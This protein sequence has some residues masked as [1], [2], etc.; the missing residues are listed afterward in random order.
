MFAVP[1]VKQERVG[2]VGMECTHRSNSNQLVVTDPISILAVVMAILFLC[3]PLAYVLLQRP[4]AVRRAIF[5]AVVNF[6]AFAFVLDGEQLT[7]D[8]D[9]GTM[10]LRSFVFY[11]WST[12]TASLSTLDHAYLTTGSTTARITLQKQDGSTHSLSANNDMGGTPKAVLAIN[13]SWVRL[14]DLQASTTPVSA[15]VAHHYAPIRYPPRSERLTWAHSR[16]KD[17]QLTSFVI[18]FC[19]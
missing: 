10:Q 1:G 16:T 3:G 14:T 6:I 8:R 19:R 18:R 11:H 7:L 15:A 5:L 12:R 17:Q 13:R 9:A 4:L 2:D